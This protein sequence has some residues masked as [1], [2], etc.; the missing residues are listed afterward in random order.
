MKPGS[1]LFTFSLPIRLMAACITAL[2]QKIPGPG[3]SPGQKIFWPETGK[4]QMELDSECVQYEHGEVRTMRKAVALVGSVLLAFSLCSCEEKISE[5]TI[6]EKEFEPAYT[7]TWIQPVYTG[8]YFI[9]FWN[10]IGLLCRRCGMRCTATKCWC[11]SGT[12][13]NPRF[14]PGGYAGRCLVHFW[15]AFGCW[16]FFLDRRCEVWLGV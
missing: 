13:W 9:C 4:S 1:A 3:G 15:L 6:Y 14:L 12:A 8:K 10:V 2:Q 11:N 7:N 5:G 16:D